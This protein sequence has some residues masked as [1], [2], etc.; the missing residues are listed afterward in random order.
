MLADGRKHSTDRRHK[1]THRT[2]SRAV[3]RNIT[4]L[5]TCSGVDDGR[6]LRGLQTETM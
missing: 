1:R 4:R 2:R 5:A 3:K 6:N